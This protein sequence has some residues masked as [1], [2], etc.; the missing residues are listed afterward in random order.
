MN[1]C[2]IWHDLQEFEQ[3]VVQLYLQRE[4]DK[5]AAEEQ[6]LQQEAAK[7]WRT[8]LN[9][10]WTRLQL[11]RRYGTAAAAA[12]GGSKSVLV[13]GAQ[14]LL[15]QEQQAAAGKA[16]DIIHSLHQSQQQ[17]AATHSKE[18]QPDQRN[19]RSRNQRQQLPGGVDD[20]NSSVVIDVKSHNEQKRPMTD[21]AE[22]LQQ[23]GVMEGVEVEEF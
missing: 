9:S 16:K 15:Q 14:A 2:C 10:M 1:L 11:Q 6:R 21:G 7:A 19:V 18:Q 23:D 4:Q 17:P 22:Q 20:K 3:D 5:A 12:E 8:L 13:G